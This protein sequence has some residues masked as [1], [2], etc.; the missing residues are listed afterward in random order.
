MKVSELVAHCAREAGDSTE[1]SGDYITWTKADWLVYYN[2]AAKVIVSF[3]PDDY[4]VKRTETLVAG[5]WQT[6]TD[7]DLKLLKVLCNTAD[8]S[9]AGA[10][11]Q[12]PKDDPTA[13]DAGWRA[14]TE[15]GT[16]VEYYWSESTPRNYEVYPPAIVGTKIWTINSSIPADATDADTDDILLPLTRYDAL[17]EWMMYLAYV[18]DEERTPNWIKAGQHFQAFFQLMNMKLQVAMAANPKEM[19][20]Y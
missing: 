1:E 9:A 8:G 12:G 15:E 7:G 13:V 11:I 6:I 19:G 14:A 10:G 5:T 20:M 2:A 18:G 3:R 4:A 16:I 17:R